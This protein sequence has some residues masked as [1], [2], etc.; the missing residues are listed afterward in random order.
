MW[1][2][3]E[4][5]NLHSE[6]NFVESKKFLLVQPKNLLI[7]QTKKCLVDS[8]KFPLISIDI[9]FDLFFCPPEI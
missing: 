7:I 3:D 8:T 1:N 5:N 9:A 6:N 4:N 2:K